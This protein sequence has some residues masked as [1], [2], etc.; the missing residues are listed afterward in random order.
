MIEFTEDQKTN[1]N[2]GRGNEKLEIKS[3]LSAS[4]RKY[5]KQNESFRSSFSAW[6]TV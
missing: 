4:L 5:L 2:L 6:K 1:D 3:T